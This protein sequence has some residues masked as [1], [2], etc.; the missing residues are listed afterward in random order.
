LD[1]RRTTCWAGVLLVLLTSHH[2]DASIRITKMISTLRVYVLLSPAQIRDLNPLILVQL[3]PPH[4]P[5]Q[6]VS[7][8]ARAPAGQPSPVDLPKRPGKE[9]PRKPINSGIEFEH[10]IPARL[11][12]DVRW[13]SVAHR[14]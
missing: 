14:G 9:Q 2:V 3:A 8:V 11:D 5:I 10:N 12:I 13:M 6:Q 4:L 1:Q 7:P